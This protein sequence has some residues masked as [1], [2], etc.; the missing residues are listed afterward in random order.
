[1]YLG[2]LVETAA[3][4]ELYAHPLHPYTQVLLSNALPAHPNEVHEEVI[5]PGE[6]PIRSIPPAGAVSIPGVRMPCQCARRLSPHCASKLLR[7]GWRV[8][9]V[10]RLSGTGA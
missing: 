6:V 8:T 5:L 1:M 10:W 3:S 7:M 2:K 4:E 9:G